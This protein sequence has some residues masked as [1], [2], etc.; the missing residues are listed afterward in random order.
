MQCSRSLSKTSAG[1]CARGAQPLL[2]GEPAA[3][4]LPALFAGA[5]RALPAWG[6]PARPGLPPE[7]GNGKGGDQKSSSLPQA[8]QIFGG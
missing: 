7:G 1:G 2:R 3:S 4:S 5:R 8:Y 6:E